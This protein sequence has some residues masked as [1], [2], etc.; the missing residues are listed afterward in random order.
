[1]VA[2]TWTDYVA[3]LGAGVLQSP[4]AIYA[5]QRWL[6]PAI[7]ADVL[8]GTTVNAGRLII[9]S[10]N[11]YDAW[12][13]S[14]VTWSPDG[15]QIGFKLGQGSLWKTGLTPTSMLNQGSSL[16][17][18]GV[19]VSASKPAWSPTGNEI[20]YEQYAV[21]QPGINRAT[22]GGASAGTRIVDTTLTAGIS[23][24]PDGSGFIYTDHSSLLGES[25]IYKYDFGSGLVTPLT[26]YSGEFAT[27]VS[28][29]PDGGSFV[30]SH[31][32]AGNPSLDLQIMSIDG[33][34]VSPLA[35]HAGAPNWSRVQPT[36]P[37]NLFLPLLR[38]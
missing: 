15:T 5:A 6:D 10:G 35:S 29:S 3:D 9:S 32:V 25:N 21:A 23:W 33:S 38:R 31:S 14:N 37:F 30:F 22:V 1:V 2:L 27:T 4:V 26:N 7:Y 24:L 11:Q 20:L 17:A 36:V 18:P 19:S 34:S 28:T 16:L 12:G 8:P 13:A